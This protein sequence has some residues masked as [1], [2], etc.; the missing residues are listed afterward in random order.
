MV[1]NK[2]SLSEKGVHRYNKVDYFGK[3]DHSLF[4]KIHKV[5]WIPVMGFTNDYKICYYWYL[6]SRKKKNP[7]KSEVFFLEVIIKH[8][9]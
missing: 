1:I 3:Y 8:S 5:N 2:C 9:K 4:S 6:L 7:G